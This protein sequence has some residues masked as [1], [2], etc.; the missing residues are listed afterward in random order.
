[1]KFDFSIPHLVNGDCSSDLSSIVARYSAMNN[2]VIPPPPTSTSSSSSMGK[3]MKRDG[4]MAAAMNCLNYT[5]PSSASGVV[6]NCDSHMC[7]EA[8]LNLVADYDATVGQDCT[9]AEVDGVTAAV[10]TSSRKMSGCNKC[11]VAY[12]KFTK[13]Q[14]ALIASNCMPTASSYTCDAACVAPL[15]EYKAL[16]DYMLKGICRER[17][18][19]GCGSMGGVTEGEIYDILNP[20]MTEMERIDTVVPLCLNGCQDQ[21]NTWLSQWSP[22]VKDGC[23]SSPNMDLTKPS[24]FQLASFKLDQQC[25][26]VCAEEVNVLVAQYFAGVPAVCRKGILDQHRHKLVNSVNLDHCGD[27]DNQDDSDIYRGDWTMLKVVI[28]GILFVLAL[29]AIVLVAVT[30]YKRCVKGEK[31]FLPCACRRSSNIKATRVP[32]EDDEEALQID[33]ID[34]NRL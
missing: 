8:L 33:G 17:N 26:E 24:A 18:P 20:M 12:T 9:A 19:G 23:I 16:W 7:I 6:I 1:M 21:V 5:T 15:Q 25:D 2:Y 14:T 11:V 29:V 30:I 28:G 27:N 32:T 4:E 13:I 22:L 3:M 31:G 34:E 10:I